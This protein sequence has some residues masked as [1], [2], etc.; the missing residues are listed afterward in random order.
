MAYQ[1]AVPQ[2]ASR[3]LHTVFACRSEVCPISGQS[4]AE[5]LV[6]VLTH[7]LGLLL[8]VAGVSV[9]IVLAS[10]YGNVWHIV[11]SSVYGASLILVYAASTFY[12]SSRSLEHKRVLKQVDQ[13]VIFLLIAGTY[14]PFTL[15]PLNGGWGWS[16]FGVAWGVAVVA[17]A[18]KV[19]FEGR[20]KAVAIPL[21]VGLGWMCIVGIV[22]LIHN[23]PLTGLLWLAFGGAAYSLG[24]IFFRWRALPFH[25][26]LWHVTVILGSL[27]H[28]F[29]IMFYVV[30]LA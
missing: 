16:L 23:V 26:A 24:T 17:M 15:G 27:F 11:G 3:G 21:Y 7:G 5:E 6:N 28:Y 18:L 2:F 20:F 9:L 19:T 13:A 25:H 1:L 30:P 8:S 29:A 12:H 4:P 10:I 22:P 14:T